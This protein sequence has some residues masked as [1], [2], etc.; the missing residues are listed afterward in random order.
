MSTKN[1]AEI[2]IESSYASYRRYGILMVVVGL[3]GGLLLLFLASRHGIDV[4]NDWPQALGGL[5]GLA[6]AAFGLS[7]L[8]P[9]LP[10]T[11]RRHPE[12]VRQAWVHKSLP[13]GE[14]FVYLVLPRRKYKLSVANEGQA[15]QVLAYLKKRCKKASFEVPAHAKVRSVAAR[16]RHDNLDG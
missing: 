3:S 16:S 9:A 10:E 4:S 6:V 8:V 2:A 14:F 13:T 15:S 11:L 7:W 1:P 5:G 12:A